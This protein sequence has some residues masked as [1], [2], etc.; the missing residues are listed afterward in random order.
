MKKTKEKHN[1][2]KNQRRFEVDFVFRNQ[3]PDKRTCKQWVKDMEIKHGVNWM[4]DKWTKHRIDLEDGE[5]KYYNK[6]K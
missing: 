6:P 1:W 3:D 2:V 4:N 5:V